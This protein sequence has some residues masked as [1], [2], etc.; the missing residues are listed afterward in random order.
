MFFT[1]QISQ[2]MYFCFFGPTSLS[3]DEIVKGL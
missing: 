3:L 2:R 1:K